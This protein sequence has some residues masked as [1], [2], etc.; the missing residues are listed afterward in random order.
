MLPRRSEKKHEPRFRDCWNPQGP[1]RLEFGWV[2]R[3]A[4][5][6]GQLLP[7]VCSWSE[8]PEPACC[9]ANRSM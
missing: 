3:K 6:V 8:E 9:K 7:T 5:L 4:F 2:K 1:L